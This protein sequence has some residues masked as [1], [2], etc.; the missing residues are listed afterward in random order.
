MDSDEQELN[1]IGYWQDDECDQ[2]WPLPQNLVRVEWNE[3]IKSCML[4]YLR[5]GVVLHEYLGFSH[6]RVN[7]GI[8]DNAMGNSELTD[9]EW[10]WP[11]GLIHYLEAHSIALPDEFIAS[12]EKKQFHIL[13]SLD[14]EELQDRQYIFEFWNGWCSKST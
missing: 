13:K 2:P 8:S 12:A 9:G 6:C 10:V 7:C 4:R 1:V 11:E 5:S 14:V 3:S